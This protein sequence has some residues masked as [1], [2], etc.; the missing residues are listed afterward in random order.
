M[1]LARH[2]ERWAPHHTWT[3]ARISSPNSF[4]QVP[5]PFGTTLHR[6]TA[7]DRPSIDEEVVASRY[8]LYGRSFLSRCRNSLAAASF[9]AYKVLSPS[10]APVID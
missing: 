8:I 2:V 3:Y 1:V 9:L 6:R 4:A 5:A 7:S 10:L